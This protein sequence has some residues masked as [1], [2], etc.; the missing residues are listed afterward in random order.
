MD[1][2]QGVRKL[3]SDVDDVRHAELPPDQR[4][5]VARHDEVGAP[6]C[7]DAAAE[8]HDDSGVAVVLDSLDFGTLPWLQ[9]SLIHLYN[10]LLAFRVRRF[11][12]VGLTARSDEPAKNVPWDRGR[13]SNRNLAR[14]NTVFSCHAATLPHLAAAR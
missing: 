10:Q 8:H 6:V 4:V 11:K 2:V 13:A 7:G 3:K 9:R 14:D 5:T 12:N 1:V